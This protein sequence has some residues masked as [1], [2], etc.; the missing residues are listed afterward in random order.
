MRGP[1]QQTCP[2]DRRRVLSGLGAIVALGSPA[3]PARAASSKQPDLSRGVNLSHWFAQSFEGYGAEHLDR[4]V[5][6]AD[7]ARIAAAGFTHVRLSVEPDIV[8]AREGA[9]ALEEG[10]V[11]RLAGAIG[12]I[13]GHR[14]AVVLDLHPVGAGKNRYL[15]PEGAD[16]LVA[17]W[18]LLA[19]RLAG[20]DRGRVAFEILNEPE[21]LKGQAW[22]RLQ[23]RIVAAIRAADTGRML[24]VNGGGW[25]G[26]EDLVA[27]TPYPGNNLVYTVHHYAPLLFTHQ[28]ADWTWDVAGRTH[29]LGWPLAP[30]EADSASR[31]A[32]AQ[33]GDRA[34]LRDQIA[35][36][37]FTEAALA[38]QFADLAA[39]RDRHGG[40]ALYC[41]EFGVYLKV[42]PPEARLRWLAASRAACEK[43]RIGWALWDNSPGFGFLTP[44]EGREI[45]AGTLSALGLG[46]A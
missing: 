43:H 14:L 8:F 40:A 36:G 2:V 13:A 18:S 27:R 16:R 44:G 12:M 17:N 5:T 35:R 34:T 11:A 23:G 24:I 31:A 19:R 30:E 33:D 7:I 15:T 46:K 38:S 26:V 10:L 37:L 28:G 3:L 41:G 22:W 32:L 42:A 39:W 25:S 6:K 4:F 29:G 9:P 1:V 20:L 45:D 21:P